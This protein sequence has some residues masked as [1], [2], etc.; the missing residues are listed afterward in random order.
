[1][2]KSLVFLSLLFA[3][4]QLFG[5]SAQTNGQPTIYTEKVKRIANAISVGIFNNDDEFYAMLKTACERN[6]CSLTERQTLQNV[7]QQMV[8]CHINHLK[9]HG[10]VNSDATYLCESKQSILGCDTLAT[11]LL[12]KMCYTG[13]QYSIKTF[14][15][16][17]IRL[18][19]KRRTPASIKAK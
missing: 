3:S 8:F 5:K 4:S 19:S 2:K 18:R 9:A 11:P 6:N 10:I 12:R 16:K 14:Q 17:E 1:M 7:G 15:E 13:N